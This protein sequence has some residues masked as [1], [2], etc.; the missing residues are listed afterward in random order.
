MATRSQ[1]TKV[2]I[3]MIGAILLFALSLFF[4]SGYYGD[5][6]HH[7]SMQFENTIL[8][9]YEG[10][11]VEYLGVTVGKVRNIKVLEDNNLPIVEIALDPAKVTL[12][13]GVEAKLSLYSMAAGTMAISLTGGDPEQGELRPG[14]RIPTAPSAIT[15]ISTQVIDMMDQMMCLVDCVVVLLC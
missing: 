13:K 12:Y 3:F 14:S 7:Y 6:G 5:G 1:K 2:G 15:A 10:A 8:G 4:V 11:I 9:L